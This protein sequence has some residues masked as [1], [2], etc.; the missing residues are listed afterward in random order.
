MKQIKVIPILL[1]AML[2]LGSCVKNELDGGGDTPDGEPTL[3]TLSLSA[4][5]M[6]DQ[7]ATRVALPETEENKFKDVRVMIFKSSGEIVTNYRIE[8]REA[9]VNPEIKINTYSGAGC[10]L[11]IITNVVDAI[12]TRLRSVKTIE[13]LNAIQITATE[14]R[15]G[16]SGKPLIMVGKLSNLEIRPG[17]NAIP[18]P[19]QMQYVS[20]KLTL[21]VVD[22]TPADHSVTILGWDIEN[23]PE[24]SF[25]ILN[26]G[27]ESTRKDAN[28]GK[29][30]E[31]AAWL[32]TEESLMSFDNVTP[33]E[34]TGKNTALLTQYLFENRRGGRVNK[35]SLPTN[36]YPGMAWTDN[37][38][39]G[40]AWFAPDRATCIVIH[41]IHK[42]PSASKLIEARIFIGADNSGNYD[43]VRGFDYQF[44]VTVKGINDIDVDTNLKQVNGDF[45]VHTSAP[46][47]QIDAHPDFRPVMISGVDGTASIEILDIDGRSYN[48]PSF[49]AKWVKVSPLNLMYHQVKQATPNDYW[50]QQAGSTG[51]FVR[52][53]YIPHKN[54]RTA[55]AAKGIGGWNTVPAGTDDDDM[56]TFT[57]ATYRMC[58]KITNIPFSPS[59]VIS[60]TLCV[61]TDEFLSN[62]GT[63]KALIK[64]EFRQNGTKPDGSIKDAEV[65]MLTIT[66]NGYLTIYDDT[67]PDA[68]L[69]VLN[70]N[71]TLSDV[72][73]QFGV[74]QY[75]EATMQMDPGINPAAQRTNSMQW[76]FNGK[77][78]YNGADRFRNGYFLTANAVYRD[79]KR[80]NNLPTGFGI[81]ANSYREMYGNNITGGSSVIPNYMG[82]TNYPYYYPDATATVYNPIYKS[83][84]ARYCH[85]KNRDINGDGFIDESETHW[86]LPS[87]H[88]LMMLWISNNI[89]FNGSYYW[90]ALEYTNNVGWSVGFSFGSSGVNNKPFPCRVRCIR[91]L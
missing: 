86:Y 82:T 23:G 71:G 64:I 87:Q 15:N 90:S 59:A 12:D 47:E 11:Y 85:E 8:Y 26:G 20:A 10:S 9:T 83:S 89:P 45:A 49:N 37:D 70:E 55:L 1:G 18:T 7:S 13:E 21:K 3:M 34:V 5:F 43:I 14:L 74:E 81:A 39:R 25:L 29:E 53:K 27:G 77:L 54:V 48:E 68:G 67:D 46:L 24:N 19:I 17:A 22:G 33:D 16:L 56:M 50:Q 35:G 30:E 84:A 80:A 6:Y 51:S 31:D 38:H 60:K 76:G 4:S 63:R 58:Y 41:A 36:R 52:A 2:L 73:K 40:K 65:R 79:V 91:K 42:A 28:D 61:Y 32:T 57:D 69:A 72:K 44:T 66:Q 62:G 78:T 88:E 75:E